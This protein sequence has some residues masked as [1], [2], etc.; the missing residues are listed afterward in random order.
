MSV[1]I[2]NIDFKIDNS[3][4]YLWQYDNANNL[5]SLMDNKAKFFED[6]VEKFFLDYFSNIFNIKTANNFGLE[7][8][9]VIL[10]VPR[11]QYTNENEEVVSFSDDMYRK[12]LLAKVLKFNINGSVAEINDYLGFIFDDPEKV[13]Y[14]KNNYDMTVEV[15]FRYTPTLEDMAVI[16][17][18]DFLPLPTGVKVVYA[19]IDSNTIFGF[20]GSNLTG[21]DT[22]TFIY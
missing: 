19:Q 20:N 17:S 21:F 14:L 13:V 4:C 5:K 22:G 11:P 9:G 10:G 3:L 8:W 7:L 2:G 12:L 6:N 16:R 1:S 15:I 18:E